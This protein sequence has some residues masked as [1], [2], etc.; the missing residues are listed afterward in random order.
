MVQERIL[1]PRILYY[2]KEQL[3]WECVHMDAC[4]TYPDGIPHR[5]RERWKSV[6]LDTEYLRK[7]LALNPENKQ[8]MYE[9]W[10]VI[11]R[12][13]SFCQLTRPEDKLL[14]I[15][16]LAKRV[17]SCLGDEYLVGLWKESLPLELLWYACYDIAIEPPPTRSNFYRA[18][19][20]SW[21]SEEGTIGYLNEDETTDDLLKDLG[22]MLLTPQ[23]T[24][25]GSPRNPILL[26]PNIVTRK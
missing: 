10:R 5:D 6:D 21:A 19:T 16:G 9:Y 20:W 15:S 24:P 23:I 2:G 8:A 11:V 14:A 7:V 3:L 4:E 22:V 13:Y 12:A 26:V 18:L 1:A 25:A 17:Q